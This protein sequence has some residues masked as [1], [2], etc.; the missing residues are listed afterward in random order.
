M[1]IYFPFFLVVVESRPLN[2]VSKGLKIDWVVMGV[3]ILGGL[4]VIW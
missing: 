2:G 4:S 1:L 3:I